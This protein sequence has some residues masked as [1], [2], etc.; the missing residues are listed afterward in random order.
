METKV[1]NKDQQS[2][3][4]DIATHIS[5]IA[6]DYCSSNKMPG[7]LAGVYHHREQTVVAHS[8]WRTLLLGL[9]CM[10]IRDSF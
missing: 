6:A 5:D 4:S 2:K 10:R 7:Y 3:L 1:A 8:V 9:Q